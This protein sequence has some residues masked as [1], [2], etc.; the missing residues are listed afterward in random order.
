MPLN[1]F[2]FHHQKYLAVGME[3][4]NKETGL[5][6]RITMIFNKIM[7]KVIYEDNSKRILRQR[8]FH[9]FELVD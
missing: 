3:I 2:S 5:S 6:G 9:K 8:E 1:L 7:I 4:R